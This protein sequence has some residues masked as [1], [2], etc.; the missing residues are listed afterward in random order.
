MAL[1][2]WD[3]ESGDGGGL[4]PLVASPMLRSKAVFSTNTRTT[5][6]FEIVTPHTSIIHLD[7]HQQH[8]L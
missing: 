7:I 6:S 2:E 4:S 8:D 3:G 5:A 1:D